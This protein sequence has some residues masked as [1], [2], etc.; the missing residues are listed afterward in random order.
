M[1]YKKFSDIPALPEDIKLECIKV[2]EDNLKNNVPPMAWYKSY[3]TKNQNSV[4]FINEGSEYSEFHNTESG[5]VGFFSIP[6]ALVS[7][8]I[9]FYKSVNHPLVR[10]NNYLLQFVTGGNFVAP[11]IDDSNA[12]IAGYIYLLKN[13][14][15]NVKTVWY[16]VKDEYKH[17]SLVEYS[18]IPYSRLNI[19]EEHRLEEDTWHWLNFSKIHS[20]ENQESLRVALWGL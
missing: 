7:K 20:V 17:L 16:E 18:G 15:T 8:I 19:A 1:Y 13:G 11:H 10:Y 6:P 12:R 5:G 2:V 14:G 4:A 9:N 3:E